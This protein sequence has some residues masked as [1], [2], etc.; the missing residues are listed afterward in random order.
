MCKYYQL[1]LIVP[2]VFFLKKFKS[3]DTK[4]INSWGNNKQKQVHFEDATDESESDSLTTSSNLNFKQNLKP[5]PQ[6]P[7]SIL[8][9]SKPLKDVSSTKFTWKS[10]PSKPKGQ[11]IFSTNK[12]TPKHKKGDS[13]TSSQSTST[14]VKTQEYIKNLNPDRSWLQQIQQ[15]NSSPQ[16]QHHQDTNNCS[17]SVES[18]PTQVSSFN[19]RAPLTK[20]FPN[21]FQ[22]S[23]AKS[24]PYVAEF[25]CDPVAFFDPV[26]EQIV[27][28]EPIKNI[29]RQYNPEIDPELPVEPSNPISGFNT[30]ILKSAINSEPRKVP[31]FWILKKLSK[32][33]DIAPVHQRF[34]LNLNSNSNLNINNNN[35]KKISGNINGNNN[36]NNVNNNN[37]NNFINN[38]NYNGGASN[39]VIFQSSQITNQLHSNT[40]NHPNNPNH[41]I[42]SFSNQNQNEYPIAGGETKPPDL[43]LNFNSFQL[44]QPE[45]EQ[46][47]NQQ[48]NHQPPRNPNSNQIPL[49][50]PTKPETPKNPIPKTIITNNNNN[51]NTPPKINPRYSPNVGTQ[52][53]KK[54]KGFKANGNARNNF[55]ELKPSSQSLAI[56]FILLLI[57][58]VVI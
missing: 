12:K 40:P 23:D 9:P 36:N 19:P 54:Y 33:N 35:Y 44:P 21:T 20:E 31:S 3:R 47:L 39:R 43:Q 26:T 16:F 8:K 24:N 4:S 34:N 27:V 5:E 52:I 32:S 51:N 49:L 57:V 1:L 13:T 45:P 18:I 17:P 53:G 46:N 29:T 37:N 48:N 22:N 6:Y 25:V 50:P 38:H 10:S 14:N 15:E 55:K 42:K 58:F 30:G 41:P 56:P 11:V 7:I 2:L 28:F